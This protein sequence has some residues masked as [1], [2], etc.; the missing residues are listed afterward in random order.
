MGGPTKKYLSAVSKPRDLLPIFT[1]DNTNG[2][3]RLFNFNRR[4]S[5]SGQCQR[6]PAKASTCKIVELKE[7]HYL[8]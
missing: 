8:K 5:V 4:T 3:K 6:E 7:T 2:T 1:K